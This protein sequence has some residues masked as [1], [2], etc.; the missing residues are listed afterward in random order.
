VQVGVI[1][2]VHRE[3]GKIFTDNDEKIMVAIADFAAVAIQNARLYHG[4]RQDLAR[5]TKVIAA[6]QYA[7]SHDVRQN[8][9]A[10]IGYANMLYSDG[11]LDPECVQMIETIGVSGETLLA[12]FERL[13]SM[14]RLSQERITKSSTCSLEEVVTKAIENALAAA[15]AKSIFLQSLVEGTPYLIRG[16]SQYL[17]LS[18]YNLLDNAIKFTP[19]GGEVKVVLGFEPN[20]ITIRVADRGP[21]IPEED[22][23]DLF[24]RYFRNSMPN[25]AGGP[26]L[27]LEIVRATVEAHM[28][29][30]TAHNRKT[31]GAEIV[32]TLPGTV[33]TDWAE[34]TGGF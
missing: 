28:G 34:S 27:G 26:G 14:A 17:Y 3:R 18:V 13:V 11:N 6:L 21:G 8:L 25:G 20:E 33:R 15:N 30:V 29:T 23:F 16:N 22:L 12:L 19:E 24:N 4:M 1:S 7:L 31:G 10:I 5:R 9:H 2:A 32:I